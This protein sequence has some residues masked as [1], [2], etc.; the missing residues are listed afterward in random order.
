MTLA[1][2]IHNLAE[3]NS[4]LR[5]L[6][7]QV[8]DL[9]GE[10]SPNLEAALTE[11]QNANADIM[12]EV[13]LGLKDL[14]N[15]IE[16]HE[17]EISRLKERRD[18]LEARYDRLK[19]WLANALP[20]GQKWSDGIHSL[21]WRKSVSVEVEQEK[22]P[23]EYSKIEYRAD[24]SLIRKELEAGAEIP[25]ARLLEKMNLIIK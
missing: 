19:S 1:W 25:G 20:Q 24:K 21:G 9:G 10:L 11:A 5:S 16:V 7:A 13:V 18:T 3:N 8:E 12:R 17:N 22:L 14:S 23:I 4:A 2:K 6:W 15:L